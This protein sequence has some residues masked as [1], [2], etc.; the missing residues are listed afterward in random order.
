MF[1]RAET[2]LSAFSIFNEQI[3]RA[4]NLLISGTLDRRQKEADVMSTRLATYLSLLM[5]GIV[6]S[7]VISALFFA[8]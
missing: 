4:G 6:A 7:W 5:Y 3:F 8:S 1:N 2:A